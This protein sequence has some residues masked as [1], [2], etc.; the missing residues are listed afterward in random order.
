MGNGCDLSMCKEIAFT[1]NITL[2]DDNNGECRSRFLCNP[3]NSKGKKAAN[4][5]VEGVDN[6]G[7]SRS[8]Q[9][10]AV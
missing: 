2:K 7:L 4:A 5:H 8:E 6:Q 1:C 3:I 9:W 10:K